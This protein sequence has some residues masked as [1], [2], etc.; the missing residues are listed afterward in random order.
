VPGEVTNSDSK[1]RGWIGVLWVSGVA[2]FARFFTGLAF[3]VQV[4][5]S[6]ICRFPVVGVLGELTRGGDNGGWNVNSAF[7]VSS[8]NFSL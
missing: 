2:T 6:C 7:W 3:G 4:L 8:E 5:S 1:D